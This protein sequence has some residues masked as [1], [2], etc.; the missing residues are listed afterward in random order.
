MGAEGMNANDDFRN[1][2][3]T[4]KDTRARAVFE[5][6]V[7]RIEIVSWNGLSQELVGHLKRNGILKDGDTHIAQFLRGD[8]PASGELTNT[9]PGS[10]FTKFEFKKAE[11]LG[12]TV[13]VGRY[14]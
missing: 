6:A 5:A 3:K 10:E 7:T 14:E 11:L 1:G 9:M 13:V 8:G 4:M 12:V 2:E